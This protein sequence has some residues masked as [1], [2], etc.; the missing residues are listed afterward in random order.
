MD[1]ST[2][3]FSDEG[4]RRVLTHA[5]N[6]LDRSAK[7][8]LDSTGTVSWF[9]DFLARLGEMG[10]VALVSVRAPLVLC[11][12]RTHARDAKQHIAVSD[13]RVA[14]INELSERLELPWAA[15]VENV[16]REAADALHRK[17]SS[18]RLEIKRVRW[19][20]NHSPQVLAARVERRR[21]TRPRQL[22]LRCRFD[23]HLR[24]SGLPLISTQ[25]IQGLSILGVTVC[26]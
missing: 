12:E 22:L 13:D 4:Q 17:G 24:Y 16:S 7:I 10:S 2:R 6:L 3:I 15:K 23:R 11:L 5:R 1:T 14:E 9:S 19:L 21:Y 20:G 25:P 18:K 8:V 26:R